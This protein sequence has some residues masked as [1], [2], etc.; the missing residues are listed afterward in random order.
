MLWLKLTAV[1]L[2]VSALFAPSAL[3][4]G[5]GNV[6]TNISIAVGAVAIVVAGAFTIRAHVASTWRTEAEAEKK[7]AD[8]LD[9][10]IREERQEQQ[11]IR[12]DLKDNLATLKAQNM[13]L[14]A[15]TDLT[16]HEAGAVI[17]NEAILGAL[18]AIQQTLE[19]L[20]ARLTT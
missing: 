8:R 19:A 12:H 16:A 11:T 5:S 4:N 1:E 17:R 10:T 2:L 18:Q 6:F 20:T 7:R 14:E 9:L 13:I 15:K 3:T